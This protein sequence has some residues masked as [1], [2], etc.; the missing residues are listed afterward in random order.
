MSALAVLLLIA[1]GLETMNALILIPKVGQTKEA[2][3]GKYISLTIAL[4]AAI[5]VVM[6]LAALRL[7]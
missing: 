4:T 7:P 3:T 6:V 1:A 2:Y 5:V